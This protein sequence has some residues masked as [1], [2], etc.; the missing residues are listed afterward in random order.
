MVSKQL[1]SMIV[2]SVLFLGKPWLIAGTPIGA[3]EDQSDVGKPAHSGSV[4]YDTPRKTYL[5]TGGGKNMWGAEDQFHYVWKRMSGDVSLAATV[6]WPT[7]GKEPHRKA[8]LIIRQSLDP[9]SAYIDAALHG[10]GLTSLQYREA[11]GERTYEIQSNVSRPTRVRLEK[12]GDRIFMAVAAPGEPLRL[13][14]GSFK[15]QLKEP[16]YVGLGV[17]AHNDTVLEKAEFSEVELKNEKFDLAK[18]PLVESTLEVV[19]I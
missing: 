8:C 1:A 5:I 18:K 15:L 14:G 9:D 2:V 13:A 10:D 4:D 12:Q 11:R 6:H 17:C 16:F 7:P 3:F 19:D